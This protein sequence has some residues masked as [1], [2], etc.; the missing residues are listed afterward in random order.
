MKTDVRRSI[1][2]IETEVLNELVKEVRE[3]L[4]TDVKLP[5]SNNQSFTAAD[6]WNIRRN[7][8]TAISRF[9]R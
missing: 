7:T 1:V 5:V 9:G 3:T 4:A 8:V 6:L 2:Q